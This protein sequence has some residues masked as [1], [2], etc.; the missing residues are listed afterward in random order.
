MQEKLSGM[1]AGYSVEEAQAIML[2]LKNIQESLKAGE[3][4]KAELIKSL[5][6]LGENLTSIDGL[7]AMTSI[8]LNS[9][10]NDKC[11][12]KHSTASQ[13]DFCGEVSYIMA[14]HN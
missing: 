14:N 4:E 8:N 10:F 5:T 11:M 9:E 2:E 1:T 6:V 3:K 13:T 12:E 7:T